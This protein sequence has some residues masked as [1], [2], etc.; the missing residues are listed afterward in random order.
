M[1]FSEQVRRMDLDAL[2]DAIYA[3]D[4][5]D[6]ARAVAAGRLSDAQIPALFSPAADA[7]L[8]K[9]AQLSAAVT[10]RRFGRVINLYCPLYLSNE[11]YNQC[12]YC[13]FS[14]E[15]KIHRISL[16]PEQVEA[17]GR[18]LHEHGFRHILLVSGEDRRVVNLGYLIECV[19][20]LHPMFDSIAIEIQPLQV[21]EYHTLVEHGVDGL[22][23]YQEVYDPVLYSRYHLSG[24][25][26]DYSKRL[27]FIEYGGEAGIRSLGIGTLLGLSDWRF[28]A[29]MLALHGRYLARKFWRSRISVSFPR[30][31]GSAQEAFHSSF[32][33]S[34][35][36]LVHMLCAMRLLLPDAEMVI[37]TRESAGMRDRL[38]G[39]GVTRASAGSRTKPGGY[40]ELDRHDGEQFEVH[41]QRSP[42]EVAAAIAARGFEPV[43]KDFDRC[44]T[45]AN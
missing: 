37:S 14:R 29:A 27:D 6:V 41:D 10:E 7:H 3:A 1:K 28:E 4:E 18:I 20:R 39:L 2:R 43:W 21:E 22:A 42:A 5:G 19:E 11:C 30:I 25:K 38:F 31:Q 13:G 24:P 12:T 45:Q 32:A 8:E 33:V 26:R 17:E 16:T 35:R 40:M 36:D 23:L 15:L 9:L 34:D 44:F